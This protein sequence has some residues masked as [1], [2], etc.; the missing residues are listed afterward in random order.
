MLLPTCCLFDGNF[1]R[2][3]ARTAIIHHCKKEALI[4]CRLVFTVTACFIMPHVC[5][6]EAFR[7]I[8]RVMPS[9]YI[10]TAGGCRWLMFLYHFHLIY[11]RSCSMVSINTLTPVALLKFDILNKV[12]Q[13]ERFCDTQSCRAPGLRRP[14]PRCNCS[15]ARLRLL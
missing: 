13:E 14:L 12:K 5:R 4:P 9:L 7:I 11:P 6:I 1:V 8:L 15:S 3:F 2:L 10:F